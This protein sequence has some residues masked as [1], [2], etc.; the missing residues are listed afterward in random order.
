MRR[1]YIA[2]TVAWPTVALQSMNAGE[3]YECNLADRCGNVMHHFTA[4][5]AGGNDDDGD[6]DAGDLFVI[7][8]IF[9][10]SVFPQHWNARLSFAR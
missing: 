1:L 6:D 7:D 5:A 2:V 3:I 8:V 10:L 9:S 4:A